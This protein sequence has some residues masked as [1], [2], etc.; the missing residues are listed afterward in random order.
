VSHAIIRKIDIE[1]AKSA[2]GVIAVF[3][4]EDLQGVKD[5]LLDALP[6]YVR[7]C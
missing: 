7:A 2:K 4:G 5:G 3:T 1:A 6:R